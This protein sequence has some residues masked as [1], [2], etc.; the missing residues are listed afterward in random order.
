MTKPH[1]QNQIQNFYDEFVDLLVFDAI[2]LNED[3][4]FGN[5]GV[6]VDN[7]SNQIIAPAP[8]F[9]HGLSL[10]CYAMD[11][12]FDTNYEKTRSPAT[13]QDFIGFV[14]PLI[15]MKQKEKLRKLIN[16]KFNR[17]SRYNL[18]SKRLKA[19]EKMIQNRAMLLL[20]KNN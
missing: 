10:L 16:F 17:H 11:E 7:H 15:T 9:D 1:Y 5:F 20:E 2:I 4:H 13:Y 18:P 14:K 12:D 19:L 8:L 6:L 3:R